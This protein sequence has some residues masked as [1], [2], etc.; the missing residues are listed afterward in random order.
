MSWE[1]QEKDINGSSKGTR[2]Y[3]SISE[4]SAD[5]SPGLANAIA[6][7]V[8]VIPILLIWGCISSVQQSARIE[9]Q[10]KIAQAEVARRAA[11]QKANEEWA[12]IVQLDVSNARWGSARPG[13]T[14]LA[15]AKFD[16]TNNSGRDVCKVGAS[17]QYTTP[18]GYK[19]SDGGLAVNGN[20]CLGAGQTLPFEV[21][22]TN[23]GLSGLRVGIPPKV[24]FTRPVGGM[25]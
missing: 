22:L 6:I 16:I 3:S 10:R 15:I 1:Y 20:P 4:N 19:Q 18:S 17:V 21:R 13:G 5:M 23:R 25:F 11:S 8:V 9:A 7:G 14:G 12:V 24:S 2:G